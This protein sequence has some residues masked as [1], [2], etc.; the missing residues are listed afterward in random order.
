MARVTRVDPTILT[1]AMLASIVNPSPARES[2][3]HSERSLIDHSGARNAVT[4]G[5]PA[6]SQG[7]DALPKICRERVLG[8]LVRAQVIVAVRSDVMAGAPDVRDK[9]RV[10]VGNPSQYKERRANSRRI[11]R[12]EQPARRVADSRRKGAPLARARAR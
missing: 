6:D 12:V 9:L 7:G 1:G 8:Q 2:S 11:E 4:C 3:A 10:L 5:T